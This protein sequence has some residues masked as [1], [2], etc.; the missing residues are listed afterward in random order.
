MLRKPRLAVVFGMALALCL[1]LATFGPASQAAKKT[2]KA[3]TKGENTVYVCA[4]KGDSSCPCMSM[5]KMKGKCPCGEHS[6][7]MKEVSANSN[8]AKKNRKA[9]E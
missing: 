6:P 2:S 4:C 5:A 8:W 7:D 9:L 1:G 3:A